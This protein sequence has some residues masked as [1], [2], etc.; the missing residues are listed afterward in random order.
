[1]LIRL[2]TQFFKNRNRVGFIQHTRCHQMLRLGLLYWARMTSLVDGYWVVSS[3]YHHLL[4]REYTRAQGPGFS[5][6]CIICVMWTLAMVMGSVRLSVS[7]GFRTIS[8]QRYGC[9]DCEIWRPASLPSPIAKL[10]YGWPWTTSY[11]RRC[12]ST[13][14]AYGN[15]RSINLFGNCD[16]IDWWFIEYNFKTVHW[17]LTKLAHILFG[18]K[19][20][21]P[22]K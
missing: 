10:W 15:L 8:L 22:G 2:I 19:L 12:Q 14:G 17:I 3:L 5:S 20:H 9:R 16:L 6:I 7:L 21:I 1:M 11:S 13:T 4:Y 18:I